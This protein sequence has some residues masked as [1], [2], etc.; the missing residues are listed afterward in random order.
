MTSED[1]DKTSPLLEFLASGLSLWIKTKCDYISELD[2][3]IIGSTFQFLRGNIS[4]VRL[5]AHTVVYRG[6]TFDNVILNSSSVNIKFNIMKPSRAFHLNDDFSITGSIQIS[7]TSLQNILLSD[8]WS[9][10][11]EFIGRKISEERPLKTIKFIGNEIIF[12]S[13]N[14][15]LVDRFTVDAKD[16]TILIVYPDSSKTKSIP[17]DSS[18]DIQRCYIS[19]N[20]LNI[21]GTANVKP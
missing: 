7:N 10:L 12:I 2:F 17:M 16:G 6:L 21:Y 18:I 4:G 15:V 20:F 11:G 5:T 1:V 14:S 19:D 8:S 13:Q 3:K 9:W